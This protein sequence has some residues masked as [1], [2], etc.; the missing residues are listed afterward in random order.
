M[1]ALVD[2]IQLDHR[3]SQ[4]LGDSSFETKKCKKGDKFR[5]L[6]PI[7]LICNDLYAPALRPLRISSCAEIIH[8]RKP[9]LEKAV[10]RLAGIFEKEGISS[11]ADA[12]RGLC[13]S[14]WGWEAVSKDVKAV[15]L[16]KAI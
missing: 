13:E 14:S 9:P 5:I 15:A 8:V 11:D 2:L 16:V 12:I 1:K 6:R 3:N 10:N 7:I 4:S